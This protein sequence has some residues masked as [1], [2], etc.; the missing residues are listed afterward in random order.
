M[1]PVLTV[2]FLGEGESEVV[3]ISSCPGGRGFTVTVSAPNRV[4]AA[5]VNWPF[6]CV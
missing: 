4:G 3:R 6:A 1:K 5:S 2:R